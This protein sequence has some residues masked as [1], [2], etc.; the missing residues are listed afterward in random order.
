MDKLMR[1]P[2]VMEFTG[3]SRPQ[4]YRMVDDGTFPQRVVLAKRAIAWRQS[5]VKTWI[6]SR[7]TRSGNTCRR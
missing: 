6:E 7:R 3:L 4:I 5:E 1:L 2:E